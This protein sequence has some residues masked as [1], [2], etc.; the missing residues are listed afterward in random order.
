MKK[1]VLTADRTLMTDY[2]GFTPLGHFACLPNRLVPNF[3]RRYLLPRLDKGIATYA[4]RRLEAS[5][6]DNDFDVT[7]L[8]PHEISK[9]K[10]IRPKAVG[11]S[12]V[13][14]LTTKPHPWTLSNIFGGGEA[15][16]ENEFHS[17]LSSINKY[18]EQ[19]GFK[20]IIGG[21][22]AS[23][24]KRTKKYH[25]LFDTYT[26]GGAEASIE[27]F[28]KAVDG[29]PLPR[30][31]T[32][33][34]VSVHELS[35]IKGAAR[36]GHVQ[37]TQGCPRGCQFCAPTLLPWISFPKERILK[38]ID[39]NLHSSVQQVSLIS[40]DVLLYGSKDVEVNH[41]AIIHLMK[42]IEKRKERYDLKNVNISNVS[43]ASTIKGKKTI[44]EMTDIMGFSEDCMVDTI[45]GLETGS[46][47]LIKRYMEGK[48]RP[49]DPNNWH[50]LAIDAIKILNDN[51]WYPICSMISGLPGENEDDVIK[52]IDL[53]DDLKGNRLFYYIFYFVPM[54]KLEG[55]D[56][57]TINEVTSRRWELFY[58]CWMETIRSL[59][60]FIRSFENKLFKFVILRLMNEIEKD[61]KKYKNDPFGFRDAYASVN[62]KGIR[63]VS[64]L[65][66]RYIS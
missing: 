28:Q 5:L 30:E 31:H 44:H 55:C 1:V 47:K 8:R 60:D 39:V 37:I 2:N 45:I 43:I 11:I 51:Y 53:V 29:D 56:F 63:L 3:T 15:V 58:I 23:E 9:I 34:A 52:T 46:E 14:P 10:K 65:A 18:R 6:L 41:R 61:L 26:T 33:R 40:E 20:I 16:T 22:G 7:I 64:F 24:F 42:D 27:L 48:A 35:I 50:D 62:L 57:F 59:R 19:N 12:T 49:F 38:E 25:D 66:K 36:C 17:L 54:G 21:P 32:G 4:L 13:D